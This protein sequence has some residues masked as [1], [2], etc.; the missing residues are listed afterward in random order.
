MQVFKEWIEF[1]LYHLKN[2]AQITSYKECYLPTVE[3]KNYNIMID[4]QNFF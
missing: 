4:G 2:E 3:T 1:L